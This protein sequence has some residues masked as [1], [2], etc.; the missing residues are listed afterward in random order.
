MIDIT[1]NESK[2]MIFFGM[3]RERERERTEMEYVNQTGNGKSF[4]CGRFYFQ[5]QCLDADFEENSILNNDNDRR[6]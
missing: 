2:L 3:Q 4:P 5:L 6:I 1:E